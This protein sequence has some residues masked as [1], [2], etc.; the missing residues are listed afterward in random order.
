MTK[1]ESQY[2][3]KV[4]SL[5]CIVCGMPAEIHHRRTGTGLKRAIHSEVIPLCH[6]HHRTGGYGVAIHSGIKKWQELYGNELDLI[7]K[8]KLLCK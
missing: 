6:S 3:N 1:A 2:L 5:G 4:A 7:E 8:V